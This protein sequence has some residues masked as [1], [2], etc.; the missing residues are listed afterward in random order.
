MIYNSLLI[1]CLLLVLNVDIISLYV[2]G[3]RV[4]DIMRLENIDMNTLRRL[5]FIT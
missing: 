5:C 3:L 4:L 2:I 1:F